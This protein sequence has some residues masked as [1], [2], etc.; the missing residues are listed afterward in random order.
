MQ[1]FLVTTV[2]LVV[3]APALAQNAAPVSPPQTERAA[4]ARPPLSPAG[5]AAP[6][7]EAEVVVTARRLD[8]A[9]ERLLPSLGANRYTLDSATLAV[10][11]QGSERTLARTLQQTPGVTQ[12]NFGQIHVRNEHANLQYRING[13]IFPEPISGFGQVIDT[14]IADSISLVTGALPAQYGYRTAGVVD[15]KTHSG[16][17]DDS[18]VFSMYGGSYNTLQPSFLAQGSKGGFNGF[19]S[20]TYTHSDLGIE[21]PIGRRQTFNDTTDQYKGFF[22]ASQILSSTTRVSAV[23]GINESSFQIPSRPGLTGTPYQGVAAFDSAKLQERQREKNYYGSV[24]LQYSDG[25]VDIQVA[26][27][28]RLS[29]ERFIPDVM[30]DLFLNGYADRSRLSSDLFGVQ[31]D[32]RYQISQAHTLR[33][34]LFYQREITH[35]F[36]NSQVFDT[37]GALPADQPFAIVDRQRKLGML[38][39]VYLQDEWNPF[40]KLTINFG[41]RFDRVEAY[42]REQ[43]FSP[44]VNAVYKFSDKLAAHIGYARNFTPPPQE[45]AA[46]QSLGLFVGT[47]KQ[48][49]SLV[50]DP[51]RAER[52]TLYDA[53]VNVTPF[54]H[55][56]L[57]L[58][59]YYKHKRNL[60]DEG[61]FGEALVLSPFNYRNGYN[62]GIELGSNYRR[63]P[64]SL[65]ANIAAAEQRGSDLVSNQFFFGANELD[66]IRTHYIYT[67]HTQ[68]LTGSAGTSYRLNNGYGALTIAADVVYG[69]GLRRSPPPGSL[70]DSVVHPNGSKLP[71]YEQVNLGIG[72]RFNTTSG[73]LKGVELR[74]DVVNLF[75]RVYQIRDGSGVGISASQ[76]GPRQAFYAGIAKRF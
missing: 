15:I 56:T 70:P 68:K 7:A 30:G 2:A 51:V 47:T 66:Y 75:D 45:L 40:P 14:R 52:E 55:V 37:T 38:Y 53:G 11:P 50:A 25:P 27:F 12:D 46:S 28:F 29:R 73:A 54:P 32:G 63:G 16:S 62:Y 39:G 65:Y 60:I 10:Q 5:A 48:A 22:Y 13:V 6:P 57:S 74:F 35:S 9:R 8:Q 1:T 17:F 76:Y 19:G 42:T 33:Y 3:A 31:A 20:F 49:N 69:S 23:F 72:Q 21:N 24:A 36:V 41:G 71:A 43:Q 4:A 18:A 59:A 67:D 58:D 26:P 44:R 61:Q 64:L 34:G